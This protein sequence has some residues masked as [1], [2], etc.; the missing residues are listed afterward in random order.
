[1]GF[2]PVSLGIIGL[3]GTG[4]SAFGQLYQ[5]IAASNAA[6]F[7]AQVARNNAIHAA[8]AGEAQA[9]D[10]SLQ[11]GAR[12]GRARAVYGA[13]NVTLYQPGRSSVSDVLKSGREATSVSAI[14]TENNAL[15]TA[16]GYQ[17][18][19]SVDSAEATSDLVGGV[20]GAAGTAAGG[21]AK[22]GGV[23]GSPSP[24]SSS[25]SQLGQSLQ[26]TASPTQWAGPDYETAAA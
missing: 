25:G 18:Q 22:Y 1:M 6:N 7:N 16:Y 10:V 20:L 19:S 11:G 9:Q 13:N 12:L 3:V 26:A 24:P 4:V 17:A 14:N 21:I 2:D 15:V 5:G 8:Q 23:F